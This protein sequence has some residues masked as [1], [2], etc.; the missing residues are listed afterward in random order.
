MKSDVIVLGAELDGARVRFQ[1]AQ[2][3]LHQR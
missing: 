1:F 2:K 3:Q